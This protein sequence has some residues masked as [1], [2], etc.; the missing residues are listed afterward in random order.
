MLSKSTK[1]GGLE[2]MVQG[3]IVMFL[4]CYLC[5]INR[6]KK[7]LPTSTDLITTVLYNTFPLLENQGEI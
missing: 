7:T 3:R 4:W 2:H 5:E 1:E 6:T